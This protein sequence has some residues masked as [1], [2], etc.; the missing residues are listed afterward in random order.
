MRPN[1]V[2]LSDVVGIR[3]RGIA[4]KSLQEDEV[5]TTREDGSS[6]WDV[7]GVIREER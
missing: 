2:P 5:E 3:S 7:A 6:T 4:N 1:V